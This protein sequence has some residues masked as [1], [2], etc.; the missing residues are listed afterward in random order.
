M[1]KKKK[2]LHFFFF[3][4][5]AKT[6]ENK[7]W[8]EIVE[9]IKFSID[10]ELQCRIHSVKQIYEEYLW[11][12]EQEHFN[13]DN[14]DVHY[15]EHDQDVLSILTSYPLLTMQKH[16]NDDNN[17]GDDNDG[18]D[19]NDT[20]GDENSKEKHANRNDPPNAC[21]KLFI[22]LPSLH[23]SSKTVV[24]VQTFVRTLE[25]DRHFNA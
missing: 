21:P 9:E 18:N 12:Y 8:T 11:T 10:M 23:N 3:F 19:D 2:S 14:D 13:R 22:Q 4:L 24:D 7:G 20:D 17:D 16:N 15:L 6:C 5:N 1:G 25:G